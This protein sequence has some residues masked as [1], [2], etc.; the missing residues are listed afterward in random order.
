MEA[1]KDYVLGQCCIS[2]TLVRIQDLN[3][4]G[5]KLDPCF[6]W[7]C[8]YLFLFL[9][10]KYSCFLVSLSLVFT[11]GKLFN[12]CR[13]ICWCLECGLLSTSQGSCTPS[14]FLST[15]RE[16]VPPSLFSTFRQH[17][18]VPGRDSRRAMTAVIVME[19]D[20]VHEKFYCPSSSAIIW[21]MIPVSSK[22]VW[23]HLAATSNY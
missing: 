4:G 10:T 17:S 3:I 5:I 2:A 7:I 11:W 20:E 12:S 21:G 15:S 8:H 13:E 9:V 6:S 23:L 19:E 16:S 1:Q 14:T 22:Q 18:T